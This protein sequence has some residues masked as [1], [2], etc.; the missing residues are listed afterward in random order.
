MGY[1]KTSVINCHYSLH[2]NPEDLQFS[3]TLLWKPEVTRNKQLYMEQN[4]SEI[5]PEYNGNLS[6]DRHVACS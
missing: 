2:I 1:L 5:V 3:S 4:W 6:C